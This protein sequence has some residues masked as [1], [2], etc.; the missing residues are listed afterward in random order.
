MYLSAYILAL[1][2][3]KLKLSTVK[4][5]GNGLINMVAALNLAQYS[6]FKCLKSSRKF[7]SPAPTDLKPVL[8][9]TI[10]HCKLKARRS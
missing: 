7:C 2:V 9:Q 8:A 10:L 1:W 4:L 3:Q 5:V 6:E